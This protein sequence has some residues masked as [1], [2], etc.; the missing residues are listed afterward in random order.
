MK[1][2]P[3]VE[4]KAQAVVFRALQRMLERVTASEDE[5]DPYEILPIAS[6][7]AFTVEAYVNSVGSRKIV[8]WSHFE[9]TPWKTKINVLHEVSG[10]EP[11]WGEQPLQ[12]ASHIFTIRDQLAHGKLETVPGQLLDCPD[13]ARAVL[14]LQ[15]IKPT[16]LDGLTREWVIRRGEELYDLLEYLGGLFRLDKDDFSSFSWGYTKQYGD[17][18]AQPAS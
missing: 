12:L 18:T 14:Y 7:M 15:H 17:V 13:E 1:Y 4:F 11:K 10:R 5:L 6:F 2:Q 9:R 8:L 16:I 3:F